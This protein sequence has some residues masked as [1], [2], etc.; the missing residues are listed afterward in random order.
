MNNQSTQDASRIQ[1]P[2]FAGTVPGELSAEYILPD[3]YPD[4]K[5]ILRTT[6]SPVL[7]G[8]YIS[9]RRLEFSG[10]V[11]YAVVFS[12]DDKEGEAIHCVHFAGEWNNTLGEIDELDSAEI[13][14]TPRIASCTV[15]LSNPRKLS[16]RSLVESDVKIRHDASC[17]PEFEGARTHEE[18]LRV[19]RRCDTT[20]SELHRSF[21]AE[22]LHISENIEIDPS[23]P[24]IDSIITCTAD[25]T[26]SEA[27]PIFDSG[28]MNLMTKGTAIVHV[29]YKSA[30]EN[31]TYRSFERKLP[32]SANV[33]AG[34]AA[35]YFENCRPDSL[36]ARVSA[37]PVELGARICEDNYGERRIIELDMTSD[38]T[39]H[40]M[41]CAN[42]DIVLD[43]YSTDRDS[44]CDFSDME[45][46]APAK[47]FSQNFSV[48]ESMPLSE[49]KLPVGAVIIDSRA[50]VAASSLTVEHGRAVL[51]GSA[52]VSC[53]YLDENGGFGSADATL[54]I[55]YEFTA[56]D[57][58]EPISYVCELCT[59]DLRVRCDSERA[60][61]DFEVSVTA[62]LA[63]KLRCRR[64]S[65]VTLTGE[66][67]Q[68][69]VKSAMTLCYPGA[70]DTLW[71]IAKRYGTTVEALE[72]ANKGGGRVLM[73]PKGSVGIVI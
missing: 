15:R 41:G 18:E 63:R 66:P 25:I 37:V 45:F 49:I 6:A 73:I 34:D 28:D 35:Q 46:T 62:E 72:A 47:L 10:A 57:I 16:I 20:E 22:P 21:L 68:H 36:S 31:P 12:A 69:S 58:R 27:R 14:V 9:G 56:G 2:A 61:F 11:D 29:M 23:A 1:I 43:A 44:T 70:G 64:V 50:D 13:S 3:T 71:D 53:I 67:R 48:G 40:I 42:A 8:R 4:V 5:K 30:E 24:P 17:S 32:I 60:Y 52:A 39:A 55:K 59:S 38:I 33:C 54:P 65:K 19:Q 51:L 26:I 7:I